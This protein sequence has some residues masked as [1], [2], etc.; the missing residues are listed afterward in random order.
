MDYN[1]QL[2]PIILKA[3]GRGVQEMIQQARAL[4]TREQRTAMAYRIV[5]VMK[6][7]TQQTRVTQEEQTKL[8]N[9]LAQMANYDLDIDYP[10]EI[11]R[12]NEQQAPPRLSY[13]QHRIRLRHYGHLLQEIIEQ[14]AKEED[15]D[16]R[17][18]LIRTVASR[19]KRNL[20]EMRG[21]IA[22][23]RRLAHDIE[24]YTDG[25]VTA[26]EVEAALGNFR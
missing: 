4:E 1:T 9:H 22:D 21:D 19:M 11:E 16:M 12:H 17:K 20:A 2:S 23:V 8:W 14:I 10:C 24:F 5:E 26:Q 13:P 15:V 7:I 3:Y 6:I 25:S 18:E